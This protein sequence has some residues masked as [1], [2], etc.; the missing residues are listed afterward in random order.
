MTPYVF[1]VYPKT[2]WTYSRSSRD[3]VELAPGV[4][5]MPNMSRR[6]LHSQER[7]T[8]HLLSHQKEQYTYST[9]NSVKY[10]G[11]ALFTDDNYNENY[12][13]TLSTSTTYHKTTTFI[14]RITTF[15]VAVYTTI[16]SV[17]SR[18]AEYPGSWLL[19]FGKKVHGAASLL[20]LWDTWLLR[21]W[22]GRKRNS[23]VAGLLM[24][25]LVP[26]LFFGGKFLSFH[27]VIQVRV[28]C[29]GSKSV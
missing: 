5:A 9:P 12:E 24:L 17:F 6:S 19:W 23:K 27:Y 28:L 15:F 3:R 4:V 20:L 1:S 29:V 26:L 18:T 11:R 2:D 22:D 8:D 25:C 21:I 13:Y 16:I 7:T 10:R 14:R